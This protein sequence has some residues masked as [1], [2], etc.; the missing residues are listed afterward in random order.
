M[1]WQIDFTMVDGG[2]G[3]AHE[4]GGF[5]TLPVNAQGTTQCIHLHRRIQQALPNAGDEAL[6]LR[7]RNVFL[8]T[9]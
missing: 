3:A 7:N 5:C 6:R 2:G 9:E 1:F 4:H 8:R